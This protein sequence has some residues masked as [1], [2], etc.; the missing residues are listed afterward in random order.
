MEK[1]ILALGMILVIFGGYLYN[2]TQIAVGNIFS[3]VS[4]FGGLV[5][6]VVGIFLMIEGVGN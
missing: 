1:G 2:G 4:F 6:F 5:L 3:I